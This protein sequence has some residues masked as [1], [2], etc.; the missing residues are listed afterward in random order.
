[1][2][3]RIVLDC[4]RCELLRRVEELEAE[5]DAARAW[6]ALWKRAATVNRADRKHYEWCR[7]R[8]WGN[9]ASPLWTRE[10]TVA[11]IRRAL[12]LPDAEAK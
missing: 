8:R 5:R 3:E 11:V 10:C 9:T 4:D 2:D 6:A 12:G 1:M 7:V